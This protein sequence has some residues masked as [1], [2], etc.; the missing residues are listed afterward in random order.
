MLLVQV[1]GRDQK[2]V[3]GWL[4]VGVGVGFLVTILQSGKIATERARGKVGMTSKTGL[5]RTGKQ[6]NADTSFEDV[7]K[8]SDC[9][10]A[11]SVL[12]WREMIW[13]PMSF[14][15][16]IPMRASCC[17]CMSIVLLVFLKLSAE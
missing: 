7:T 2:G 12:V 3:R 6:L 8:S 13:N 1:V 5:N 11:L 9:K 14:F 4:G 10:A 16:Q 17:F 15:G